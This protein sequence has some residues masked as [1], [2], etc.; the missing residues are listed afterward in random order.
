[1]KL[2]LALIVG[3]SILATA[4]IFADN[5]MS[6]QTQEHKKMMKD[7]MA[8]QKSKDSSMSKDDMTKMCMDKMKTDMDKMHSSAPMQGQMPSK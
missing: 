3:A 2:T 6:S 5:A 7:C 4:P 1:M 8:M